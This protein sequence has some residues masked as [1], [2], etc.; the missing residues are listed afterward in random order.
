MDT[1]YDI[2]IHGYKF[3]LTCFACPEQYDVY[4]QSGNQVGY[5][6][7]RH[8]NFT[9]TCPDYGGDLVYTA[10]P[11]GDGVFDTEE[12][13]TYLTSAAVV[14]QKWVVKEAFKPLDGEIGPWDKEDCI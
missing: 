12:R 4:D 11:N 13:L 5:L 8:G 14:I 2:L 6:R 3:R 7:L 9:V 10:H 1:K